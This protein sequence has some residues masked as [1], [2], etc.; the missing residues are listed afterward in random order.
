[1]PIGEQG[2]LKAVELMPPDQSAPA[3]LW[4]TVEYLGNSFSGSLQVDDESVLPKLCA[5]LR[6]HISEGLSAI[7]SLEIDL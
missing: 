5:F 6:S 1:L 2:T 4:L 7:G 3:H